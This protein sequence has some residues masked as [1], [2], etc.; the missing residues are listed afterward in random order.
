MLR[1]YFNQNDP[2]KVIGL[3]L[4]LLLS[5]SVFGLV[6]WDEVFGNGKWLTEMQRPV[7]DISESFQRTAGPLYQWLWLAFPKLLLLPA[8]NIVLATFFVLFLAVQFNA[9]LIRWNAFEHNS[10]LPSAL[11]IIITLLLPDLYVLS[12]PLLG[13]VF[14]MGALKLI[15]N[16]LKQNARDETILSTGVLTALAGMV[17]LPYLWFLPI[18]VLLYAF[19]STTSGR[20]YLLMLW[21]LCMPWMALG[22]YFGY[23]AE[24][25]VFWQGISKGILCFEFDQAA[26]TSL[27]IGMGMPFLIAFY[28]AFQNISG[29]GMNNFQ[30]TIR[31][32]MVWLGIFALVLTLWFTSSDFSSV[33]LLSLPLSYFIN[34][35]L[36]HTRKRIYADGLFY[37]L[38]IASFFWLIFGHSLT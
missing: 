6:V 1:N 17:Y 23:H 18:L 14:L 20:R 30:I 26:V 13:A 3:I 24:M 7:F 8:V 10:Y 15:F 11:F 25:S 2:Y 21:G 4:L 22:L 33:L 16:H 28:A 37:L 12:A 31:A 36:Q 27:A 34:Q 9:L 32:V 35:V 19:Y 38:L 5:R 29:V